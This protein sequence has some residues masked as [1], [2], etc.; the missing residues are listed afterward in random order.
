MAP[1]S[2][3]AALVLICVLLL[4]PSVYGFPFSKESGVTEL[5]PATFS[6]FIDTH[7]PVVILFYAPWCGHCKNFHPEYEKFARLVKGS[8]RVGAVNADTHS[9]LGQ[10][11]SVRGFPT[12]KYWS[13][14]KN[15]APVDYNNQRSAGALQQSVLGDVSQARVKKASGKDELESI[16]RSA[17]HKK[18]AVLISSKTK[19]PALFSIASLSPKLKDII[20]VFVGGVTADKYAELGVS[21]SPTILFI[22]DGGEGLKRT[23]FQGKEIAYDPIARFFLDCA[24]NGTSTEETDNAAPAA[25]PER[26]EPKANPPLA[27]EALAK[28]SLRDFCTHSSVKVNGKIPL[29]VIG[30][31]RTIDLN[32]LHDTFSRDSVLFFDASGS[33]GEL[34][35]ALKDDF[36]FTDGEIDKLLEKNTVVVFRSSKKN[37]VRY[38]G[39]AAGST[40]EINDFL[41]HV[42]NGEVRLL[43]KTL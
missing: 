1:K 29:C 39:D 10:Q 14:G 37:L 7:K 21:T 13:S 34:K 43:K 11:F 27:P 20:F 23:V 22:E 5:T 15:N 36:S 40:A 6:S 2:F 26:N 42:L 33:L 18:A 16:V 8:I 35:T 41:Q 30:L 19:V 38:T 28:N 9:S 4:T 17:P 31:Q 25:E 3:I 32:A 24:T 12:I